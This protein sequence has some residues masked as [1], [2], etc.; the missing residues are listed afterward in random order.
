MRIFRPQPRPHRP[1]PP[2]TSQG[3]RPP[4]PSSIVLMLIVAVMALVVVVHLL[5]AG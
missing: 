2:A 1:L 4:R 3:V 5:S